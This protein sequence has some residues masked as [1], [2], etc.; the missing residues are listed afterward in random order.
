MGKGLGGFL[1]GGAVTVEG[2]LAGHESSR[3]AAQTAAKGEA[4]G[5]PKG[6]LLRTFHSILKA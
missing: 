3:D 2:S 4:E 6:L 5:P 1:A